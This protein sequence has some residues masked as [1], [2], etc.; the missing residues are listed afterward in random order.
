ML[1]DKKDQYVSFLSTVGPFVAPALD[2]ASMVSPNKV[3]TARLFMEGFN[4]IMA[5]MD[6]S[7][8]EE[9]KRVY[10][11]IGNFF[12]LFEDKKLTKSFNS[13][14]FN[15]VIE[16][17]DILKD[18]VVQDSLESHKLTNYMR[19]AR[20]NDA[21]FPNHYPTEQILCVPLGDG[22]GDN[23][24]TIVRK[25]ELIENF[26]PSL[27][28]AELAAV[29]GPEIMILRLVLVGENIFQ[30]CLPECSFEFGFPFGQP[31]VA[32]VKKI[33]L[34][35]K[36]EKVVVEQAMTLSDISVSD[37][38][39]NIHLATQFGRKFNLFF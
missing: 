1:I 21:F 19:L 31:D 30:I 25:I 16:A 35:S 2:L 22:S 14:K 13:L 37:H 20:T 28:S 24:I 17:L 38:G 10:I 36:V 26:K 7:K 11:P 5:G 34:G 6:E 29:T 15:Q 32:I 3:G 12:F 9:V 39:S 23:V 18:V 27:Q 8:S 4:L 33:T